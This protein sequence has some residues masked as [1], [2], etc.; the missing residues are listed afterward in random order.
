MKKC[1]YCGA[2]FRT[3]HG[4]RKIF[5]SKKCGVKWWNDYYSRTKTRDVKCIVCGKPLPKRRHNY[6]S[7]E[8]RKQNTLKAQRKKYKNYQSDAFID[9]CL[10]CTQSHCNG[11][12][13]LINQMMGEENDD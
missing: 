9:V 2:E 8:C 12:C 6:C 10:N 5:C 11:E 13:D 4:G 1:K 7:D 3:G